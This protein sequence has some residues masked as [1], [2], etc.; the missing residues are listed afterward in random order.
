MNE[1]ESCK[2]SGGMENHPEDNCFLQ[3]DGTKPKLKVPILSS[4]KDVLESDRFV[5]KVLLVLAVFRTDNTPAV[6]TSLPRRFGISVNSDMLQYFLE[7][8]VDETGKKKTTNQKGIYTFNS[9]KLS[10][11]AENLVEI[12]FGRYPI[13]RLSFLRTSNIKSKCDRVEVCRDAVPQAF[14][15]RKYLYNSKESSLEEANKEICKQWCCNGC[16]KEITNRVDVME[17]L[18]LL[19]GYLNIFFNWRIAC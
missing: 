17:G 14:K 5:D 13:I 11:K 2:S 9:E 4:F 19:I 7:L 12:H 3:G 1:K 6:L 15:K 8:E 10:H 16:Y 18:K